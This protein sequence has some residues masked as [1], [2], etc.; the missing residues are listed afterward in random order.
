MKVIEYRDGQ[1]AFARCVCKDELVG[2]LDYLKNCF[3]EA[4]NRDNTTIL[5]CGQGKDKYV[6][7]GSCET[8]LRNEDGTPY[9]IKKDYSARKSVV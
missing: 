8:F 3:Y 7:L 5:N 2:C 6:W 9:G 4:G 1:R